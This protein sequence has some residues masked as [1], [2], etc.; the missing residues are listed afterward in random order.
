MPIVRNAR[1]VSSV[2]DAGASSG[3]ID[4]DYETL[5]EHRERRQQSCKCWSIIVKVKLR[6]LFDMVVMQCSDA[7]CVVLVALQ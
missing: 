2:D 7:G 4:T 1:C 3:Q 6:A 5:N